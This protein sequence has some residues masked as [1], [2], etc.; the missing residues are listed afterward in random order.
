MSLSRN[1][2]K[3]QAYKHFLSLTVS[4]KWSY[5]QAS[6]LIKLTTKK[7]VWQ[8]VSEA[9]WNKINHLIKKIGH[10]PEAIQ[11]FLDVRGGIQ[12]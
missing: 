3:S 12:L 11:R 1:H 6:E 10:D 7:T 4:H 8:K 2:Q 9:K 5:Q